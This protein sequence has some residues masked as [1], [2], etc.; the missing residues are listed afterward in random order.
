MD[1]NVKS[2]IPDRATGVG[3]FS[4]GGKRGKKWVK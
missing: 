2:V 3:D 4:N 1:I